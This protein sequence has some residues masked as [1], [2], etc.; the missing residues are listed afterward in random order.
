MM[1]DLELLT[2]YIEQ[3][4]S[5]SEIAYRMKCSKTTIR[6]HAKELDSALQKRLKASGKRKLKESKIYAPFYGR[7]YGI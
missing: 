5:S 4:F 2:K 1:K 6:D 7:S 3:D